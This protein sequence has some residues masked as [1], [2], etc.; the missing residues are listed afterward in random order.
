MRKLYLLLR[1]DLGQDYKYVQ[2]QH[3]IGQYYEDNINDPDRWRNETIVNLQVSDEGELEFWC[4]KMETRGIRFS[5]FREPDIGNQLTTVAC[6]CRTKKEC[7][8]FSKLEI[9]GA[10]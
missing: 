10:N 4:K 8:F 2:S 3:G 9:T 7:S 1:N 6:F 5:T